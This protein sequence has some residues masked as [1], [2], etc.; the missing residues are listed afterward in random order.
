M[1]HDGLQRRCLEIDVMSNDISR[2]AKDD[3]HDEQFL[4]QA[5]TEADVLYEKGKQAYCSRIDKLFI[6]LFCV[7]WPAAIV[8]ALFMTPTTW[9]GSDSS[10]HLHVYMAVGLG[11]LATLFPAWLV[12]QRPGATVTRHVIAAST[13]IFTA[14]FIHLSGGRDEGHFHFFMMMAFVALYFDW[15]VVMTAIVVGALDHVLRTALVPMSVFGVLESPWFQ[16]FRHVLWVVFEGAVLLFAAVS[17][18]RDKRQSAMQLAISQLRE[19][20]INALVAVNEEVAAEREQRQLEA[21]EAAEAKRAA[22]RSQRQ[23]AEAVALREAED[24]EYLKSQ[25]QALLLSVNDAA[26]GNLDTTIT[27]KGDDAIGQ[28]G[29]A[30]E[31]FLRSLSSNFNQ[32]KHGAFELSEAAKVLNDE[33]RELG[34]D[35][36]QA[37]EQLQEAAQSANQINDGVQNTAVSTEQMNEAIREVSRCASEAVN[38]GQEAVSLASKAT[39]TVTQL[40]V[41]SSDIGNVLKVITSIAEQT[42]LLALNA[43]IEA[44]RAGDAGKG[45]AVV[46]NEVKDLAKETAN[47]TG[48]ISARIAAIQADANDAG[49]VIAQISMIIEQ[50]ENYQT[51]VAAAV[52]EQTA[53]TREISNSVQHSA[54]GSESISQTIDRVSEKS[55]KA[56]TTADSVYTSSRGLS[57]IAEKLN[58]LLAVY[59]SR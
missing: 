31:S 56:K 51:T 49:E 2:A 11:A 36:K 3:H 21:S 58:G 28:V 46:A 1:F 40:G 37:F 7:Q 4:R 17:I 12:W 52:E 13:M 32:I 19:E 29:T 14:L 33:S 55:A 26:S 50:I 34:T 53:T 18:D 45:F 9:A 25:V 30:L 57:E 15:K 48:E 16:L 44:A 42:N 5:G 38:V 10:T 22:E 47:A 6:G 27:V 23:Q 8:L 43:T 41:S 39:G 20:Q 54:K 35:S 59:S 24:A